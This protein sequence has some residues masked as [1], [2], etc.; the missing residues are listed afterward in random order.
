M[1]HAMNCMESRANTN[2]WM[3]PEKSERMKKGIGMIKGTR[4]TITTAMISP[5]MTFPNNRAEIDDFRYFTDDVHYPQKHIEDAHQEIFDAPCSEERTD[6]YEVA[7]V[8]HR[9]NQK[10]CEISSNDDENTECDGER[11][12]ACR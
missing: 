1:L 8:L 3:R 5:A 2:A 11:K 4:K 7:D 10:S 9:R 12:V 6:L